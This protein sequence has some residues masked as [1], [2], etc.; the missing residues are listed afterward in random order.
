MNRIA[1]DLGFIQIYWYSIFIFLGVFFGLL[2][3]LKETKRLEISS[4]L[5]MDLA[6]SLIIFGIIGARFY[7][8]IFNFS[9]YSCNLLEIFEIWN[10][11]LAIHGAIISGLIVILIYAHKKEINIYKL[12]DIIV[13]A[14]IIGQVIGRWGN[15]FNGE[16]YGKIISE[17]SLMFLPSFIRKGMFIDGFFRQPLFLYE[18]I[19]NLIG[20]IVMLFLRVKPSLRNGYLTSFYLVWYGIVRFIIEGFRTDSLMFG[21]LR[22]AYLTSLIMIICGILVYLKNRKGMR[23]KN[24]YNG[25]IVSEESNQEN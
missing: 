14:L 9:Y 23:I 13:V 3:A 4:D 6:F 7:Y 19:L 1:L 16:A 22:V 8:V 10:G 15:F 18:S 25:V 21:R 11:G 2:Y 17:R 20:L 5:I 24:L 12:L